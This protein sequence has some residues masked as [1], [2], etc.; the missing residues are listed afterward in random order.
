MIA[1]SKSSPSQK[2]NLTALFSWPRQKVTLWPYQMSEEVP[3]AII[4]NGLRQINLSGR[5]AKGFNC[6]VKAILKGK[7]KV[8][9]LASDCDHNDYKNLITGLCRK[10]HVP[11]Q[12]FPSKKA[13][14]VALGLVQVRANGELRS[15][16]HQRACGA[17][18]LIKYGNTSSP[19]VEELRSLLEPAPQHPD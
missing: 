14:G 8:V 16:S 13:L 2:C 5:V 12:A 1:S 18:A 10:N 9:F 15:E 6:T 3:A 7:A 11:L 4:E 17:C 19:G